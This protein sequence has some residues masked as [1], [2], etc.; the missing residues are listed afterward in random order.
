MRVP[1][2]WHLSPASSAD[3]AVFEHAEVL[4]L[5]TRGLMKIQSQEEAYGEVSRVRF[6][7]GC[8]LRR[9]RIDGLASLVRR[10]IFFA[11]ECVSESA[12]EIKYKKYSK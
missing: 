12:P 8:R 1:A 7:L 3:L 10:F 4:V 9:L 5:A 11:S 6:Y 2:L